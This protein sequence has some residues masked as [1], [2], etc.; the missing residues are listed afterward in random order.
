MGVVDVHG[1][2]KFP[3]YHFCSLSLSLVLYIVF[4]AQWTKRKMVRSAA[5]TLRGAWRMYE[6][7]CFVWINARRQPEEL[8][9][10]QA[11]LELCT[12]RRRRCLYRC[13]E[14]QGK[15]EPFYYIIQNK[16][17]NETPPP[18]WERARERGVVHHSPN[19][20]PLP[21]NERMRVAVKFRMHHAL[22]SRWVKRV[23]RWHTERAWWLI[24]HH[25]SPE[26][27][28]G[29]ISRRKMHIFQMQANR[30]RLS[31]FQAPQTR[32]LVI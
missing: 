5:S 8:A 17:T 4:P 22:C 30:R 6:P 10:H 16:R 15:C 26:M 1:A 24:N 14:T 23:W 31:S 2:M 9:I 12:R 28:M 13:R 32:E 21:H 20:G 27:R 19:L 3:I 18:R 7:R 11:A 29:R 25:P